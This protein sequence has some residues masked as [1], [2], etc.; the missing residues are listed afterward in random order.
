MLLIRK[1]LASHSLPMFCTVGSCLKSRRSQPKPRTQ[2]ALSV[3][4]DQY[5][6]SLNNY[7]ETAT[8]LR[9]I[10]NKI[11]GFEC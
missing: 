7:V 2:E 1:E 5:D 10:E 3:S 8:T 4:D 6:K 9:S 11:P